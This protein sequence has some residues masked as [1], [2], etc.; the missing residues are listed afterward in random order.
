[1]KFI[2][3]ELPGA[4][5]LELEKRGDERGFFARTWC[6]HEF[7]EHG[8]VAEVVQQ[9]TSVSKYKGTL[10]GMHYQVAPQQE[11][12]LVRC[13]KGAL[14]D[15]IIDL[16]PDSNTYNQWLGVEL[17]ED[18]YKMLYVPKDFAHGFI[19]LQDNTEVT[20]LVS[21]FYAPDAERGIRY[22]DPKIGIKWPGTVSTLSDK[23]ASWPL[24]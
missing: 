16:R 13:T 3:T 18:N 24:L 7:E 20:Y 10:R 4:Y 1:V 9:N 23:D 17:T 2:E 11:T 14:F 12:K 22:N 15:V 5:I 8:L 21:A 19:T 6:Q